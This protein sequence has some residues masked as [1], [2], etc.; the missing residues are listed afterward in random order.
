MVFKMSINSPKWYYY[1]YF[2]RVITIEKSAVNHC[3]NEAHRKAIE[4]AKGMN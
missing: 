3:E 1:N 2:N 4:M